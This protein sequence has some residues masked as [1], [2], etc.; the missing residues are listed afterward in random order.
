MD[1]SPVWPWMEGC[2]WPPVRN[3]HWAASRKSFIH[4]RQRLCSWCESQNPFKAI[5]KDTVIIC[6]RPKLQLSSL[7][8]SICNTISAAINRNTQL[9][10]VFGAKNKTVGQ[11]Y[12]FFMILLFITINIVFF[13]VDSARWSWDWLLSVLQHAWVLTWSCPCPPAW[14]ITMKCWGC[15]TQAARLLMET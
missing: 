11:R 10:I 3:L 5:C 13:V 7:G 12:F 4:G 9:G 2:V 14:K 8:I 1:C 15:C 6:K